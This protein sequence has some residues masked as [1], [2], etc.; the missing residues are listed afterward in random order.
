MTHQL[1]H[2][3]S[4]SD[5]CSVNQQ[6]TILISII[7]PTFEIV[8]RWHSDSRQVITTSILQSAEFSLSLVLYLKK[9]PYCVSLSSG[10]FTHHIISAQSSLA[11]LSSIINSHNLNTPDHWLW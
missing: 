8:N 1:K 11:I 3:S 9:K 7:T 6:L 10:T 5:K 4:F 2:S